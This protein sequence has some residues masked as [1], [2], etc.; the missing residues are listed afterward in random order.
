MMKFYSMPKREIFQTFSRK[1]R[2]NRIQK[3]RTPSLEGNIA[4]KNQFSPSFPQKNVKT[5]EIPP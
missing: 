2:G 4:R 1:K 3:E 5:N